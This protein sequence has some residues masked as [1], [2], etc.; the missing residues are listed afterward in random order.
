MVEPMVLELIIQPGESLSGSVRAGDAGS[1]LAFYGWVGLM[2]AIDQLR[3]AE[4][5]PDA[6]SNDHTFGQT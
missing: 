5:E 1:G 3:G 4:P 6:A 2:A